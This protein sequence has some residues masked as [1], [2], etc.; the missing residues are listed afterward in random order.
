LRRLFAGTL[1]LLPSLVILLFGCVLF[2]FGF[3]LPVVRS[4]AAISW[5]ATPCVIGSREEHDA[6]IVYTYEFDGREYTS[7]RYDFNEGIVRGKRWWQAV[8]GRYSPGK[9][10]F[11]YVNPSNPEQAVL[12]R[13]FVPEVL[14]TFIAL[15]MFNVSVLG[16]SKA[17]Q[18]FRGRTG[19]SARIVPTLSSSESMQGHDAA[20]DL[21]DNE[22]HP[23]GNIELRRDPGGTTIGIPPRGLIR[24]SGGWLSVSATALWTF[25]TVVMSVAVVHEAIVGNLVREKGYWPL[26]VL[27]PLIGLV[28]NLFYVWHLARLRTDL[29]VRNGKLTI[30]KS[31]LFGAREKQW[32]SSEIANVR[33]ASQTRTQS[34]NE[35]ETIG[36]H[37]ARLE[38]VSKQGT[39]HKF[40][41][42]CDEAQLDWIA[43][44]VRKALTAKEQKAGAKTDFVMADWL[45][46]LTFESGP[47]ECGKVTLRRDDSLMREFV[48]NTVCVVLCY[49][50]V[51]FAGPGVVRNVVH[52]RPEWTAIVAVGAF[53]IGGLVLIS[54]ML[55]SLLAFLSPRPLVKLSSASIA[56]GDTVQ[57][58]WRFVGSQGA[59]RSLEINLFGEEKTYVRCRGRRQAITEIFA[60]VP[61]VDL[62]SCPRSGDAELTVPRDTMHSFEASGNE[63]VWSVQ[64]HAAIDYLPDVVAD[65]PIVVLPRRCNQEPSRDE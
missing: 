49:G 19:A 3:L 12:Q 60:Q 11:C 42:N 44:H 48:S 15:L 57:L 58:Q 59:L 65:F 21:D 10:V 27:I 26:L 24:G 9:E 40:F 36:L 43:D 30:H 18:Y 64:V 53:A 29:I 62:K 31:C 13:R 32:R 55:H 23:G 5:Q 51:A 17:L 45:P 14:V 2:A 16:I 47:D 25:V 6:R 37:Q 1:V 61:I 4:A 35:S 8:V 41:V 38:V 63:I 39:S 46:K 52:G 28:A 56:L 20:A 34:E 50:F 54:R 22:H 33:A 7:E